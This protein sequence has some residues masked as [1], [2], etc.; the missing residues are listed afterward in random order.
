LIAIF[1]TAFLLGIRPFGKNL[2][3]KALCIILSPVSVKPC[4]E[5]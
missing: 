2:V 3:K 5:A 4:V 1:S